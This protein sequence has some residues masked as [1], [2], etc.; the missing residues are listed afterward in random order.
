MMEMVITVKVQ[1]EGREFISFRNGIAI[2]SLIMAEVQWCLIDDRV[3]YDDIRNEKAK[4][5]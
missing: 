4:E 1:V 5:K 2:H 3:L